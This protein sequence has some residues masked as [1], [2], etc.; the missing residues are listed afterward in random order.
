MR[1]NLGRLGMASSD[2][3]RWGHRMPAFVN[4]AL[5]DLVDAGEVTPVQ[6]AGA[7][8]EP[9]YVLTK[10]LATRSR[11]LS[12]TV[13]ILSPFDPL[14][15]RRRWLEALFDFEYRLE[16]YVP[17]AKRRYGYFCLPILW[18]DRFVG[19]LDPK[20]DRKRKTFI[21]RKLMFEPGFEA[22]EAFLPAFVKTLR[23]FV[24]F[25]GCGDI[26]VDET[27]PR[28]VKAMLNRALCQ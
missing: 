8:G 9:R 14:V 3:I 4:S 22:Y 24:A 1:W 16:C 26:V 6:V 12:K 7:D 19:R 15:I 18:G 28:K 2:G 27:A 17:A 25:N 23:A 5:E 20:A 11:R 21:V 13:H 10:A